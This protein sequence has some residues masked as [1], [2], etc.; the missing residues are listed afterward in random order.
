VDV[1]AA[2][3]I[4]AATGGTRA[5]GSFPRGLMGAGTVHHIAWRTPTDESQ[6]AWL[7][8]LQSR[9][10]QVSPVMDRQYFHSIYFREPGGVL[11][12]IATDPPGFSADGEDPE[13][14]GT[15]L[16]LPAWLEERR[17]Q[18]EQN[19]SPLRLPPPGVGGPHPGPSPQ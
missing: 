3:Q 7:K 17:T 11:F 18:I 8:D 9:G 12:E 2:D 15:R 19:L 14:L 1:L 13:S 16:Q 6:A 5:L 4:K 10:T